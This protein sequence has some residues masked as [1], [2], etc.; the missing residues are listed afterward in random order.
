MLTAEGPTG[1]SAHAS[2]AGTCSRHS[3]S[4]RASFTVSSRPAP[5]RTPARTSATSE[6]SAPSAARPGGTRAFRHVRLQG[7]DLRLGNLPQQQP[8]Q[9]VVRDRL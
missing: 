3:C 9:V 2:P 5:L 1:R 8:P 4:T 7:A 6:S